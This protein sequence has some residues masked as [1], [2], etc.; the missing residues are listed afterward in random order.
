MG[1]LVTLLTDFGHSDPYVGIV[2]GAILRRS[3]NTRI[4]DLCHH[5]PA[6]DI[7]TG[8]FFLAAARDRFPDETVHVGVVDPGVGSDRAIL[9]VSA[10]GCTWVGPD[11][12]LLDEVVRSDQ[13]AVVREVDAHGVGLPAESATFHGR[14]IFGP[15]GAMLA[16]GRIQFADL[17]PI[18]D[19]HVCELDPTP[20]VLFADHFGNLVT[21]VESGAIG[22]GANGLVVAGSTFPLCRTYADVA[23]GEPLALVNSYGLLEI[24]VREGNAAEGLAVGPGDRVG[25]A[26]E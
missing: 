4:V 24:A 19:A 23:I 22:A 11:N 3:P 6:F 20:R 12:G 9:A 1:G 14:D 26:T 17:G 13:R 10:H 5:V 21:S 2:H 8:A 7:A 18:R 16:G 25:F 15:L